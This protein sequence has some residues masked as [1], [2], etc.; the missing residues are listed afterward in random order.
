MKLPVPHS[1]LIQPVE[2]PTNFQARVDLLRGYDGKPVIIGT[3]QTEEFPELKGRNLLTVLDYNPAPGSEEENCCS[4]FNED[5]R[6][7]MPIT[8]LTEFYEIIG[9]LKV[10]HQ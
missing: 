6:R 7:V 2:L 3:N 9:A 10:P 8:S 1:P 4:F 5:R